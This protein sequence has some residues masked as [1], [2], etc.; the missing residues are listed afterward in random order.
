MN[1]ARRISTAL[2]VQTCARA[3]A[4]HPPRQPASATRITLGLHEVAAEISLGGEG[5]VSVTAQ[6]E[7]VHAGWSSE[8]VRVDVM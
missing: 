7:I 5:V 3:S 8:S 6:R 4:H 1:I 2:H